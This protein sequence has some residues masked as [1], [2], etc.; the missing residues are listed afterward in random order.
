MTK[1]RED[2]VA[3]PKEPKVSSATARDAD[4]GDE[5]GDDEA[6]D[7][8]TR[9]EGG[10]T[11]VEGSGKTR[12]ERRR[13]RDE[14]RRREREAERRQTNETIAALQRTVETLSARVGSGGQASTQQQRQE[15]PDEVDPEW[16]KLTDRQVELSQ[17]MQSARSQEE[18]TRI[19]GEW[20]RAE[21]K[22]QKIVASK[23]MSPELEK[24]R[25]SGQAEPIEMT[26]IRQEFSDVLSDPDARSLAQSYAQ[27]ELVKARRERRVVN[28]AS[29]HRDAILRAGVE[30]G[31]RN[32]RAPAPTDAQRGRFAA[33]A[34][35]GNGAGGGPFSRPLGKVEMHMAREWADASGVPSEKAAAEWARMMLKDDPNYFRDN[36]AM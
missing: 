28:P 8:Q 4:D 29:V 11:V 1:N 21:F 19:M 2:Q 23:T 10:K 27:A 9:E 30:L 35:G 12:A 18:Q 31:L 24:V 26:M 5:G 15:D 13:E 7:V 17:L 22:K 6:P 36:P 3:E 25:G 33:A 16:Q 32:V 34:P 14:E 20:R